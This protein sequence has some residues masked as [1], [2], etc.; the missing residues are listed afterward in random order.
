MRLLMDLWQPNAPSNIVYR[1]IL[2]NGSWRAVGGGCRVV[3]C[4]CR[5][6]W[7]TL[8]TDPKDTDRAS[9]LLTV[10]ISCLSAGLSLLSGADKSVTDP[11]FGHLWL[12]G[13]P[14]CMNYYFIFRIIPMDSSYTTVEINKD[15]PNEKS[16]GC[17][18]WTCYRSQPFVVQGSRKAFR[19]ILLA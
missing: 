6:R 9:V 1:V 5:C 4:S 3:Q 13:I 16:K 10:D 12:L 14:A 11:S 15:Q 2:T 19:G 7:P 17:L 8:W 18:F